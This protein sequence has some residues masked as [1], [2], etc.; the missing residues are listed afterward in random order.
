MTAVA[1]T[2]GIGE[3]YA[4]LAERA[5]RRF[6][7]LNPG[8]TTINIAE[9]E[10]LKRK[11]PSPHW[12]KAYLWDF[13]FTNGPIIWFDADI[14]PIRPLPLPIASPGFSACLDPLAGTFGVSLKIQ[15]YFNTGFF[16]AGQPSIPAF[17]ALKV[18]AVERLNPLSRRDD[19][20]FF[21]QTD[22]NRT[23]REKGVPLEILPEK[24]NWSYGHRGLFNDETVHWHFFNARKQLDDA[25][26]YI[27]A[28]FPVGGSNG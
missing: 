6:R 16:I 20:G 9:Q 26:G 8:I 7:A 14:I 17:G 3:P 11:L 21:E 23:V 13:G 12:I 1:F 2:C 22:L 10:V 19:L 18:R 27:D 25:W 4:E 5:A 15:D 28:A 24:Y